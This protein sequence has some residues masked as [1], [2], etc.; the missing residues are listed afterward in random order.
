MARGTVKS[1]KKPVLIV[2][3]HPLVRRGM[4][5]LI[6]NDPGLAVCGEASSIAEALTA[7]ESTCPEVALVDLSL[8]DGAGLELI[9]EFASRYPALAVLVVSMHEE[10]LYAERALRA[11]ARGYIMKDSPPDEV[12]KA[13]RQVLSGKVYLSGAMEEGILRKI[14]GGKMDARRATPDG[15]SDRELEV[16]QSM[17]AGLSTRQIAERMGVS[18]KTVHAHREHIRTKMGLKDSSELLQRAIRWGQ[19]TA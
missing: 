3:D 5:Q 19:D 12:L 8:K 14:V 16:F 2:D 1:R 18:I 6:S 7:A 10:D 11:G 4:A 9:K 17:G 15:L 13:I